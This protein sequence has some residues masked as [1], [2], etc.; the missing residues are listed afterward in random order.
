MVVEPTQAD[1]AAAMASNEKKTK[2]RLARQGRRNVARQAKKKAAAAEDEDDLSDDD[3]D[4]DEQQENLEQ[5]QLVTHVSPPKPSDEPQPST[6]GVDS[7]GAKAKK[8]SFAGTGAIPKDTSVYAQTATAE[9][10]F[11]S[12]SDISSSNSSGKVRAK[13]T[14]VTLI[15]I[16]NYICSPISLFLFIHGA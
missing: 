4:D 12:I 16:F 5:F 10:L 6:S 11:G 15:A 8:L 7:G 1:R 2:N 3:D 13:V 9:D 14:E